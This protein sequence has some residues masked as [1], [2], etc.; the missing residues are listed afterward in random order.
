[1]SVF[2]DERYI[3]RTYFHLEK[4]ISN[5]FN[6]GSASPSIFSYFCSATLRASSTMVIAFSIVSVDIVRGGINFTILP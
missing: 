6:E 4:S 1:M 3:N 5:C 2:P